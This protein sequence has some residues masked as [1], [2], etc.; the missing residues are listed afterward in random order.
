MPD[1]LFCKIIKGEIP[2]YKIYE[3]KEFLAFLDIFPKSVGHTLV[4]PKTHIQWVWDYPALGAYFELVGKLA[5]HL[6]QVSGHEVRALI[7]G[8]DIPH[9]HIHL[10]PGRTNNLEGQ[11]MTPARLI[12]IQQLFTTGKN[13]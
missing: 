13:R 12:E 5:R 9:A 1:C 3:D 11:K 10:M 6:R 4:I 7:Y 8:F 2:S